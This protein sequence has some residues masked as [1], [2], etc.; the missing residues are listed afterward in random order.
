MTA[1]DE[2]VQRFLP[3]ARQLARRYQRGNE[4]LDDLIQVASIGLVKAVDRFDPERGTAFSSYA[5]PTILGEL[6]RYFRDSGWAVHVPRGMQERVMSVNQAI[7]RLS[8]ETGHSPTAAEVAKEIGESPEAVLEAMEA[9]IAYDSVSLDTPRTSDEDGGDTYADTMGMIDERFELVEYKS[10]IGPTM[11]AL[12]E[13]DR[14][15]LKLRFED[16]LTQL[17]IAE[18]IGVSQMHVSRLIRRALKRL[19]TVAD[20]Q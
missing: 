8:R 19:R 16:D 4:P 2:L 5:V 10:A 3:L 1:R 11:R 20:A 18:R 6:K 12:P 15:V 14:L 13:R 9:A 7:A 17:E